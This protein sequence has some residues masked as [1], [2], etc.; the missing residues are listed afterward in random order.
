MDSVKPLTTSD[1]QLFIT[2]FTRNNNLTSV[3]KREWMRFSHATAYV[4]WIY[5]RS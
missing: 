3:Q 1:A 4:E 5:N 2:F